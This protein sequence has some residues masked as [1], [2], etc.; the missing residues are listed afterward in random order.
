MV[1]MLMVKNS[2]ADPEEYSDEDYSSFQRPK[3]VIEGKPEKTL[4]AKRIM[5][6]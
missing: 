2:Y 5:G 4:K 3:V 6:L 1:S